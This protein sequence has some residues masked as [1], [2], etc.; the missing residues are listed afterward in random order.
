MVFYFRD[1]DYERIQKINE[2]YLNNI[3]DKSHIKIDNITQSIN[4]S[5]QKEEE[6]QTLILSKNT[7]KLQVK[8]FN[9][10]DTYNEIDTEQN[11]SLNQQVKKSTECS[12]YVPVQKC[13]K[14]FK[15][16]EAYFNMTMI[17]GR[18]LAQNTL[19]AVSTKQIGLNDIIDHTK[20]PLSENEFLL[21]YYFTLENKT[22][23][24]LVKCMHWHET[25]THLVAVAYSKFVF[26]DYEDKPTAVAIWSLKNPHTPER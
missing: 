17:M 22:K 16:T 14:L 1:G 3:H 15:D 24:C 4:S 2:I 6:C 13:L 5:M 23:N 7:V 9:I 21:T 10:I 26:Y 12:K 20:K 18:I 19:N 8:H 25:E 11:V